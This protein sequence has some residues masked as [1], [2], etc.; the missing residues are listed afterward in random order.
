[1]WLDWIKGAG[2]LLGAGAKAYG[3]YEAHKDQKKQTK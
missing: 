2:E 3:A 1:M